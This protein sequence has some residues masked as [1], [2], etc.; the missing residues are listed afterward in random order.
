MSQPDCFEAGGT[1]HT[2]IGQINRNRQV[3]LGTRGKLG[4]N[5]TRLFAMFCLC[6]GHLY[7]CLKG[8]V[9]LR[10]CPRCDEGATGH[11]F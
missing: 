8:D 11:D 7:G 1:S 3:C 4:A 10:K 6:C 2:T 9:W 5:N